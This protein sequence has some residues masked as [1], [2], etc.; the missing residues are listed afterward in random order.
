MSPVKNKSIDRPLINYPQDNF[1]WDS[2]DPT[3]RFDRLEMQ[4][5][6]VE[7]FDDDK[8]I[9]LEEDPEALSRCELLLNI[10]LG[11]AVKVLTKRQ[12]RIFI[13]RFINQEKQKRIAK[14]LHVTQPY[15]CL[16]VRNCMKKIKR[17][18]KNSMKVRLKVLKEDFVNMM[19]H[20]TDSVMNL[21]IVEDLKRK[22]KKE[23]NKIREN[24]IYKVL[25]SEEDHIKN[26]LTDTNNILRSLQD[27]MGSRCGKFKMLQRLSLLI[28]EDLTQFGIYQTYKEARE[29]SKQ[30]RIKTKQEYRKKYKSDSKLP[31]HPET[32]YKGQGWG[33]WKKF[34][35]LE[36]YDF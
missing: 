16:V 5:S 10:C 19:D 30:L 12:F 22:Q 20:Y 24:I 25:L 27:G 17:G 33:D 21:S 34:L 32:F 1:Y 26:I 23:I 3:K 2:N 6:S 8:A 9:D 36:E 4:L 35:K 7:Q 14:D 13:K 11:I 28:T 29:A 18:I 31:K 15:V